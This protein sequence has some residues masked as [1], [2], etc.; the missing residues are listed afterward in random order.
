MK[1]HHF[2]SG[3]STSRVYGN[4]HGDCYNTQRNLGRI[5]NK[6]EKRNLFKE[7]WDYEFK[8]DN[9]PCPKYKEF[10]KKM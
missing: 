6:N 7:W 3:A 5:L 4:Y 2:E 1:F 10:K 8:D 9:I